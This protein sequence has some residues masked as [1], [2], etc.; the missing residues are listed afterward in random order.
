MMP[1]SFC[2]LITCKLAA[3]NY[4]K[5]FDSWTLQICLYGSAAHSNVPGYTLS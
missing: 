3:V 2:A 4:Y 1:F 5:T